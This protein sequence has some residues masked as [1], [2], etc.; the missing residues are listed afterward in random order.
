MRPDDLPDPVALM[1]STLTVM[2]CFIRTRCP[3]QGE[4]VRRQL[5]YLQSYPDHL[6]AAPFKATLRRLHGDWSMVLAGNA[7]AAGTLH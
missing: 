6:V 3:R 4:L 7:P 2:T 5:D 1:T